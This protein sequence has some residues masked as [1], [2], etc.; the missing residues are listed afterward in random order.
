MRT[1]LLI[2]AILAVMIAVIHSFLGERFV[3]I[4]LFRRDD[5]P[6][7]FGSDWFTR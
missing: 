4:R 2:A 5:L 1:G 6:R 7:L 3:L